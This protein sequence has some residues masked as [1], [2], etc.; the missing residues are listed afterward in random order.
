MSTEIILKEP[1]V[2]P[3]VV[4][5]KC[6]SMKFIIGLRRYTKGSRGYSYV[7]RD[8]ILTCAKCKR[9]YT[10]SASTFFWQLMKT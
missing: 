3:I 5:C 9:S 6:G 4:K 1:E 10:Y 2:K 8:I 7:K